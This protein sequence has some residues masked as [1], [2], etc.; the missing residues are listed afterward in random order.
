M[1]LYEPYVPVYITVHLGRP[2]SNARNVTVTFPEYIKN[3]A[4]SEIYPTWP[5]NAI[6]ANIYAQISFAMNRIYTE[7]Y[8]S[9]GYDFD[10]TSST[11]FDQFFVFG[12][13]TFDSVNRIVDEIFNNYLRRP[14]QNQP[15]LAQYC[16]GTSVT[17]AGLSQW[18]TVGLA[19]QGMNPYEILTYYYG[20]NLEIVRDAP[21]IANIPSYPGEALRIG[22]RGRLLRK[23]RD[24]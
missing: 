19:R 1:A 4:S 16:N 9:Q 22:S 21:I 8:R 12:R 14:G 15:L 24:G 17:C 2:E 10:I 20:N 11:A 7:W 5:E 6:R 23:C 18:G 13:D 3:V